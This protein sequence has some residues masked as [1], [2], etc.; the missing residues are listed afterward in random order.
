[1]RSSFCFAL[2]ASLCRRSARAGSAMLRRGGAEKAGDAGAV[3]ACQAERS[4]ASWGSA[5]ICRAALP[6]RGRG[7]G[8]VLSPPFPTRPANVKILYP[9]LF[10]WLRTCFLPRDLVLCKYSCGEYRVEVV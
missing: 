8:G 2:A 5:G 7:E 1:M 4:L 9:K 6:C 3:G 10:F